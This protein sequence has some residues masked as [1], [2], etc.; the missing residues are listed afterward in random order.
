[1]PPPG[2][3]I[4]GERIP[5]ERYEYRGL[6]AAAWDLLRGDTSGW[7]D[8]AF[9]QK[10][11][12]KWGEPVLDVGC[13]TGRLLVDYAS[14]GIDIDGVEPQLWEQPM[15]RL[16]LPRR[17]RTILVPSSS[18][19]L[20]TDPVAATATMRRF[21]AHLEPGGGLAMSFMVMA[22]PGSASESQMPEWKVVGE[23][24]RP[25]DGAT[26]RRWSRARYDLDAQ[27]E[28]TEDRYEVLVEDRIVDTEH[29]RRSPSARWYTQPQV[30]DLYRVAGFADVALY[31][32]FTWQPAI[33]RNRVFCALGRRPA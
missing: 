11:V 10:V 32:G 3:R 8:R 23:E 4:P 33:A 20:V 27:L 5:D 1:V 9:W 24:V 22:E 6:V 17:Y 25:E 31:R 29:H 12:A 15:D 7:P 28:H 2:E 30:V 18:F 19:Q 14:E 21:R 26:V 16:D 13:G